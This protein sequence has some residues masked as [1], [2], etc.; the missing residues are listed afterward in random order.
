MNNSSQRNKE[1]MDEITREWIQWTWHMEQIRPLSLLGQQ[2][3]RNLRP[4]V[5]GEEETWQEELFQSQRLEQ[6]AA[7]QQA[8]WRQEWEEA[9][10][11]LPDPT[12]FLTLLET[13]PSAYG[14]LEEWYGLK[15]FLWESVRLFACLDRVDAG[16]DQEREEARQLL[17]LLGGQDRSFSLKD[18]SPVVRRLY[19][20]HWEIRQ[21]QQQRL[22]QL[23]QEVEASVGYSFADENRLY[24]PLQDESAVRRCREDRQ[25]SS[26]LTEVRQTPFEVVFELTH[27]DLEQW[28]AQ[29]VEM[30]K[31]VAQAEEAELRRLSE[32]LRPRLAQLKKWCRQLSEW[33]WRWAKC[34]WAGQNGLRW[35]KLH[36]GT[37]SIRDGFFPYLSAKMREKQQV[38][39]TLSLQLEYGLTTIVGTNMGGK[40][41]ALKTIALIAALAHHALPVPAE[42]VSLPL[43]TELRAIHGD[44]EQLDEGVS[45]FGAEMQRLSTSLGGEDKLLLLDELARGTNPQ[46]GEALAFGVSKTLEEQKKHIA[47]LITHFPILSALTETRKYRV[48]GLDD[49]GRIDYTLVEQEDDHVPQQGLRIARQLGVNTDVLEHARRWLNFSRER[50]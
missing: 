22:E 9:L 24:L 34:K 13:T 42:R 4:F 37:F 23:K 29:L 39:R 2:Y 25:V 14:S 10:S 47:V 38:Y 46:E 45:T 11:Q 33:D 28:S 43:M 32:Q 27:P 44:F 41:V 21:Q 30:E 3:K 50:G 6:T 1:W 5:K 31:E 40:S 19:R 17:Q 49:Q 20:Q 12:P 35:P 48:K 26:L 7:V 8:N 18:L 16:Y 36:P 15:R